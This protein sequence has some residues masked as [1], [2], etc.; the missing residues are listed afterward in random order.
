MI[1]E[2]R[3]LVVGGIVDATT[4]ATLTGKYG[5]NVTDIHEK[6][7][8][9][10]GKNPKSKG[11][12]VQRVACY[13][14]DDSGRYEVLMG[15]PAPDMIIVGGPDDKHTSTAV[16]GF[17][18]YCDTLEEVVSLIDFVRIQ[19]EMRQ[20]FEKVLSGQLSDFVAFTIDTSI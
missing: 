8:L 19:D 12:L 10:I 3:K 1:Q 4:Y 11:I 5:V 9:V 20:D 2:M 14:D 18:H 17:T 16:Y 13:W 6:P 7:V 15:D